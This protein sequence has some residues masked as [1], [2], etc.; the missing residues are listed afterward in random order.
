MCC[1]YR[2]HAGVG[3]KAD[4]GQRGATGAGGEK[5]VDAGG[6]TQ[7]SDADARGQ[8]RVQPDAA[9]VERGH[10]R[11]GHIQRQPESRVR[12]RRRRTANAKDLNQNQKK[13]KKE[14]KKNK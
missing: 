9:A 13:K 6:K 4:D 7:V 1:V 5:T 10:Q 2:W 8:Q 14:D 12:A 3:P 11:Q